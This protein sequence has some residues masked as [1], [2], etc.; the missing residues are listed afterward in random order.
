MPCLGFTPLRSRSA[1]RTI[2]TN[3]KTGAAFGRT[4]DDAPDN[5]SPKTRNDAGV[6]THG[7]SYSAA[8]LARN[9]P[10]WRAHRSA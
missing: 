9:P 2:V 7:Q 10:D 4:D 3:A 5:S 1:A 8:S 6:R